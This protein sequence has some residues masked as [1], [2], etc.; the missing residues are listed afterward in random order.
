MRAVNANGENLQS[1]YG[2]TDLAESYHHMVRK[3]IVGGC[4][5]CIQN[6]S[7]S[8]RFTYS[9]GVYNPPA[10]SHMRLTADTPNS[11]FILEDPRTGEQW[12]FNDFD[13]EMPDPRD[14]GLLEWTRRVAG[15]W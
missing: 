8:T 5:G 6:A 13:F 7:E 9:S 15:R 11:R 14:G 2:G 3:E 10:G 12:L 4:P 1:V